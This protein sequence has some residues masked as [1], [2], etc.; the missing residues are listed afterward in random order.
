MRFMWLILSFDIKSQYLCQIGGNKGV[1]WIPAKFLSRNVSEIYNILQHICDSVHTVDSEEGL[2]CASF[3]PSCLKTHHIQMTSEGI[4]SKY[5]CIL[6][7]CWTISGTPTPHHTSWPFIFSILCWI[8][9]TTVLA[10][11][12]WFCFLWW[13]MLTESSIYKY[14]NVD[15]KACKGDVITLDCWETFFFSPQIRPID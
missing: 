1:I 4:C 12:H 11:L 8:K 13:K 6:S 7:A 3:L 14:F 9:V 10:S 2:V 15:I 5:Y